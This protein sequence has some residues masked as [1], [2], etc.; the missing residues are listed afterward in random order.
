MKSTRTCSGP[1]TS[2]CTRSQTMPRKFLESAPRTRRPRNG[3][4]SAKTP[5]PCTPPVQPSPSR[6][7][8]L[9]RAPLRHS[10][11]YR[12]NP[13]LLGSAHGRALP[14][15]RLIMITRAACRWFS[16]LVL[17]AGCSSA[18]HPGE[19]ERGAVCSVNSDC[20]AG[21]VC[22]IN[23]G[24]HFGRAR[25][26]RVCWPS[27]CDMDA[28]ACGTSDS[29]CGPDCAEGTVCDPAQPANV[30]HG[31]EVCKEGLGALFGLGSVAGVCVDPSCP[32]N[33]E[34]KC[35]RLNSL[36]GVECICTP[37]CSKATCAN[38]IDN[39]GGFCG[40]VCQN[41][42]PCQQSVQCPVGSA[43]LSS[44]DNAGVC[45]PNM[46]AFQVLQPPLCGTP[47]APCGD[48]CPP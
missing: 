6:T 37:D 44:P 16:A 3:S 17:L 20:R 27:S 41:G 43:C 32:S 42:D 1:A 22:G 14:Q 8:S 28:T 9:R 40:A 15:K 18:D 26:D 31:N 4:H 10:K 45:L 36:C 47:G 29:P 25:G 34:T 13:T 24:A 39:C 35:G 5:S 30:C 19:S 48:Q 46:C 12:E 2:R 11:F 38:P 21:L 7:M 23:N 33:D